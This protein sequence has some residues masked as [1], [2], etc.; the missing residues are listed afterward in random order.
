MAQQRILREDIF[1]PARAEN[2]RFDKPWDM[3]QNQCLAELHPGM[4]KHGL[5]LH[6]CLDGLQVVAVN[7]RG[8]G[9]RM[10][11]VRREPHK[12]TTREPL[13]I[14][15]STIFREGRQHWAYSVEWAS[16]ASHLHG[17][18]YELPHKEEHDSTRSKPAQHRALGP[19]EERRI[20]TQKLPQT[21]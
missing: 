15:V 20:L 18:P 2:A 19:S 8:R 6:G 17:Q 16:R 3:F 11:R 14:D 7:T 1:R 4:P 12:G 10:V 5:L 9:C 13:A 21:R